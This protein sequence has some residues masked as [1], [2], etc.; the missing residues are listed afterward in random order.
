MQKTPRR[1]PTTYSGVHGQ[2][3]LLPVIGYAEFSD[4]DSVAALVTVVT[5]FML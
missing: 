3:L 4:I 1:P 2:V 5:I